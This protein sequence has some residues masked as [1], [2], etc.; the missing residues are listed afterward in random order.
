MFEIRELSGQ[1]YVD[2]YAT[3]KAER[4]RRPRPQPS[5]CRDGADRT[6]AHDR[7]RPSARPRRRAARPP[8]GRDPRRPVNPRPGAG[9]APVASPAM[10]DQITITLP[11]GSDATRPRG[12]HRGRPG[13]VDRAAAWPRRRSIAD[14]DGDRARPRLARSPTATRS[15]IVTDERRP[16]PVHA[17]ATRRPTCWP[18]RCSTCSPAPRSPSARRSRTASTTTSSCPDGAHVHRRRPRAHRGPDARDHRRATSRSCATSSRATTRSQLFADQ[19]YK[20][21][22]H[23]R[24]RPTTRRR[25]PSAGRTYVNRSRRASAATAPGFVDLCRG[26]HVPSHRAA[27]ATSSSC[28]W[29]A[30]TG[31][32]TRSDPMLQRIYG[33]AWESQGGARRA[34]PPARGGREARPPQ[35]RRR[36]RPVLVPR[37]D[38]RG[39]RRLAPEGRASCAG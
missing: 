18:R 25:R 13:R 12:H 37:G 26:P 38:R 34:P 17:S 21:R 6:T 29:P 10:A 31:A 3:K 11:D 32:A 35:A 8:V 7:R 14:V 23:R 5:A 20:L 2:A 1:E 15:R 4:A 19:P 24:R 33:T 9:R 39:P 16:R 22:D 36:A 28:G 30:R 27:S